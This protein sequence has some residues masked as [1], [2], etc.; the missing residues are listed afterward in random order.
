M[1]KS[2][3]LSANALVQAIFG[4][5]KPTRLKELSGYGDPVRPRDLVEIA[6]VGPDGE[7]FPEPGPCRIVSL[8]RYGDGPPR[9]KF[10]RAGFPEVW[11]G[12]VDGMADGMRR[13]F[14]KVRVH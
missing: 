9:V 4:G 1:S 3:L 6:L 11:E 14:R 2:A 5:L 8:F 12:M 13:T 10:R 7:E